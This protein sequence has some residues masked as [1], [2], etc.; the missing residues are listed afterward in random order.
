MSKLETNTIDTVSGT[1]TLQVGSTN[2]STITLGV[3]GDTIN[4]PSGVTINNNG[5][6]TG[7]GGTNTPNFRAYLTGNQ[8]ISNATITRITFDTESYDTDNAFDTSTNIFTVPSGQGGKYYCYTQVRKNN[9]SGVRCE[10]TMRLVGGSTDFLTG[11]L[12]NL[13]GNSYSTLSTSAVLELTAGQQLECV[14]YHN[15]GSGKSILG[16]AKDTYFGAYK[17]IE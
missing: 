5:T 2:T 6:Q 16:G 3:S 10:V 9:F 17:I 12:G 8:S 13:A 1:S 15:D 11:E 14:F 7:F 4:V